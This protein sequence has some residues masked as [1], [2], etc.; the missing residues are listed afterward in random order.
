LEERAANVSAKRVPTLP[1]GSGSNTRPNPPKAP[2]NA[3]DLLVIDFESGVPRIVSTG[4]AMWVQDVNR[5]WLFQPTPSG[6]TVGLGGFSWTF[7][8][9]NGAWAIE[10]LVETVESLGTSDAAPYRLRLLWDKNQPGTQ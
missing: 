4:G 6:D 7:A 9:P 5:E 8:G 3:P 2:D 1:S 10:T